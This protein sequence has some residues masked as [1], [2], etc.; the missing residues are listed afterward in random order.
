VI[1]RGATRQWGKLAGERAAIEAMLA[2]LHQRESA[3]KAD[4]TAMTNREERQLP[5]FAKAS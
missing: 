2:D 1:E 4:R 5:T 3:L